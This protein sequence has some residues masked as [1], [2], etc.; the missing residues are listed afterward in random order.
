VKLSN[1]LAAVIIVGV[2]GLAAMVVCLA[3]W[4]DWSDGAVVGM[5]S[6]IGSAVAAAIIA[7]RGQ[8]KTAETLDA[9]DKVLDRVVEQTNGL[10]DR[11]RQDIALRAAE[12]GAAAAIARMKSEGHL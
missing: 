8:Q 10:S 3:V 5:V 9:Q 6:G 2:L 12:A 11:E 7:V 1:Q 4:A